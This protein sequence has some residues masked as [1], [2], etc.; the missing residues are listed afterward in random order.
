VGCQDG[1][2]NYGGV[3]FGF[4]WWHKSWMLRSAVVIDSWQILR[5]S[6]SPVIYVGSY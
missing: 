5:V 3:L 1:N 6:R 4:L 2:M